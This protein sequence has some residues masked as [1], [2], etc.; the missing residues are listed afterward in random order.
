[1][2]TLREYVMVLPVAAVAEVAR[3]CRGA[4]PSASPARA[5]QRLGLVHGERLAGAGPRQGPSLQM[6]GVGHR[7]RIYG[8]PARCGKR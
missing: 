5:E 8:H 1:M 3:R 7:G 6:D 4:R 2:K